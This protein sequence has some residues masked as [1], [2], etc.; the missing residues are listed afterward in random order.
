MSTITTYIKSVNKKS[1]NKASYANVYSN[2]SVIKAL[3]YFTKIHRY[4]LQTNSENW[5]QTMEPQ[6]RYHCSIDN[7]S[8]ILSDNTKFMNTMA[9]QL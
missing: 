9:Y 3:K 4:I 1:E 8:D 5:Y 2:F 6:S 7:F